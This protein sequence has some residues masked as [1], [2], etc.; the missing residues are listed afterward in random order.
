MEDLQ[1][2]TGSF[3]VV[4]S[5]F[6]LMFA[7]DRA[8]VLST[9]ARV[10]V[11]G[12]VLAAAV[13]G[14][15][16]AHM[17]SFGPAALSERLGMSAP[18]PGTPG[19]FAMSD[20]GACARELEAA[21]F[22]DV[23]VTDGVVPFRFAS[24]EDYVRFNRELLPPP[25]LAIVKKRFGSEDSPHAWGLVSRAVAGRVGEDGTLSLPSVALYLRA[26]APRR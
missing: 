24:I 17:L 18:P 14:P 12:G 2:E 19:P 25:I 3:D 7:T 1:R 4:L 6:G 13:W 22:A 9:L 21:G 5:R 16:S 15:A 11:P 8:R 23:S 10:L 20:P 26:S